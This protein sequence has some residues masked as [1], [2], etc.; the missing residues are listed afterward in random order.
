MLIPLQYLMIQT[1]DTVFG[2][3]IIKGNKPMKQFKSAAIF[4]GVLLIIFFLGYVA[5]SSYSI[6]NSVND[7]S[8]VF[9]DTVEEVNQNVRDGLGVIVD[10]ISNLVENGDVQEEQ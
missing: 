7:A 2:T 4:L 8:E 1:I 6:N 5:Y 3:K 10:N 9:T